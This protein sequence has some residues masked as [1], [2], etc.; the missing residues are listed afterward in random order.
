MTTTKRQRIL[1]LCTETQLV[2]RWQRAFYGTSLEIASKC[3]APGRVRSVQRECR[4]CN[5]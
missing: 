3:L 1:F 4:D 5:G 2:A